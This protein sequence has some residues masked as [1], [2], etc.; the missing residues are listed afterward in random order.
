M[1][2]GDARSAVID[3]LIPFE[4]VAEGLSEKPAI[5]WRVKRK[6]L[7][8]QKPVFIVVARLLRNGYPGAHIALLWIAVVE[9]GV[10]DN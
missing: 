9:T 2:R 1:I 6:R 10:A 8:C 3:D 5:G 7:L 4:P